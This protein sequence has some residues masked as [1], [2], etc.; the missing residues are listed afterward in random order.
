M[1]ITNN[2]YQRGDDHVNNVRPHP[3]DTQQSA[4]GKGG[5]GGGNKD[6]KKEECDGCWRMTGEVMTAPAKRRRIQ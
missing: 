1:T 6:Y 4:I 3:L 5:G 2:K